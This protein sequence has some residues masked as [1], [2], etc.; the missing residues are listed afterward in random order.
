MINKL[1]IENSVCLAESN[2]AA[3][4]TLL[5]EGLKKKERFSIIVILFFYFF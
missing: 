2:V 5:R 4:D 3:G 1:K